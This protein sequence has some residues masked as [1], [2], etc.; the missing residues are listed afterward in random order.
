[1]NR[2]SL[3]F[4]MCGLPVTHLRSGQSRS[5]EQPAGVGAGRR[6][7]VPAG[8]LLAEPAVPP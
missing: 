8:R 5:Q 1:M 6:L 7:G 4:G 3:P 2:V